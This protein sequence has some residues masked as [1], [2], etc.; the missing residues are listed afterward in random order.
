[1]QNKHSNCGLACLHGSPSGWML[2]QT[3]DGGGDDS[4]LVECT[5]SMTPLPV[6]PPQPPEAVRPPLVQ[7]PGTTIKRSTL[8]STHEPTLV[9]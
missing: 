6:R 7:L 2:I 1:M 9:V 5:S 3:R 8:P 4:T